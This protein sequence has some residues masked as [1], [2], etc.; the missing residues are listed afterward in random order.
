VLPCNQVPEA[1]R[2]RWIGHGRAETRTIRVIDLVGSRDGHGEFFP[3][4]P[5]AEE[6]LPLA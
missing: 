3:G 6:H 2:V 1:A 5:S 4:P